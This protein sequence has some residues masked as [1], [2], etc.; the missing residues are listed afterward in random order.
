[1]AQVPTYPLC[2]DRPRC[3]PRWQ[4]G[5]HQ[6]PLN[7][8]H[9]AA[10][11]LLLAGYLLPIGVSTARQQ[12]EVV[13]LRAI[14]GS[15]VLLIRASD[16]DIGQ[17]SWIRKG[18]TRRKAATQSLRSR[19]PRLYDSGTAVIQSFHRTVLVR[20]VRASRQRV[21]G[22]QAMLAYD[23]NAVSRTLAGRPEAASAALRLHHGGAAPASG[24][25]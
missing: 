25:R 16:E 23:S 8:R 3:R 9:G 5:S 4:G 10:G 17:C 12:G 11:Y 14:A 22:E 15:C 2:S 21:E 13:K 20:V 19:E 1:M 7:S 6:T 24:T 18:Q